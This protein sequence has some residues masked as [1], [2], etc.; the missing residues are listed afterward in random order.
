MF[1]LKL[2]H[3]DTLN[4]VLE[5]LDPKYLEEVRMN[6]INKLFEQKCLRDYRLFAVF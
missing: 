6:L 1:G 5:E 3:Q 4:D 2:P